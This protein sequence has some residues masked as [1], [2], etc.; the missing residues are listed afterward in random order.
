M[1]VCGG[2]GGVP[3]DMEMKY[4]FIMDWSYLAFVVSANRLGFM[5]F[6]EIWG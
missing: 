5:D 4:V 3:E 1:F 2:G 6:F